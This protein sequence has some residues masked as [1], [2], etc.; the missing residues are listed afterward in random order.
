MTEEFNPRAVRVVFFGSPEFAV[1]SLRALV[2]AGY[3]VVAA[4]TQPD[5]PAGRGS[6]TSMPPVKVAA[7]ELG[8]DVLQPERLRDERVQAQLRDLVPDV[9]VVAAYGKIL[10]Q[11]VLD[12]PARGSLNVHAS[13]LPRWRGAS[14]IESAI[15]AGDA[16]TGVT[17]MELVM[18]MDAGPT[19]SSRATPIGADE[20]A[21]VLESRLAIL[22]SELLVEALPGWLDGSLPG[23][24]QDEAAVTTCS[25]IRKEDGHLKRGMTADEAAR[26]VRAFNPWPGAYVLYRGDRLAIWRATAE[27]G[28]VAPGTIITSGRRPAVG[29]RS[30]VLVLEEVQRPGSKRLR[31][32]DFVNGERGQL[33]ASVVLA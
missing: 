23:V 5:K 12:I 27:P 20:T 31:G 28:T 11:S 14:P 15:L 18:K 16:E 9:F 29:F 26:A 4:V 6:K 30:G 22:G 10:P 3:R 32:E 1:P 8:I 33:A 2:A 19:V 21:G 24:S 7:A 25:L 17:I 13:L